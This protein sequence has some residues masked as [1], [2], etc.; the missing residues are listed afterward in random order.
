MLLTYSVH[1]LSAEV[2]PLVQLLR[3]KKP[4][5]ELEEQLDKI[6]E[7]ALEIDTETTTPQL[8]VIDALVTTLCYIGSKTFSHVLSFIERQR[9]RLLT[10]SSA[11]NNARYQV[12]TSVVDYW[13][14]V[15]PGVAVNIIDKLL[16]YGILTPSSVVEWALASERLNGGRVLAES[17]VYEMV[18]R[19]CGKVTGRVNQIVQARLQ[20]I[21]TAEQIEE[22]DATLATERQST[23]D[24]FAIID[25]ALVA[26]ADG[27]SDAVL[28]GGEGMLEVSEEDQDL[29]RLWGTKWRRV[30]ARKLAVLESTIVEGEKSFPGPY[31]EPA[32]VHA[33][34][35]A[36]MNGNGVRPEADGDMDT[37]G[38][39][40]IS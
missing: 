40:L 21:N 8:A 6:R 1:P 35:Y 26:V 20:T 22:L 11:P 19:T 10:L 25:D 14:E 37:A 31:E 2:K 39:D 36:E 7:K 32:P 34:G 24:L 18:S 29:L 23:R 33:D 30:F 15:Q 12:I 17:W 13:A 38:E 9:E 27:S 16:N 28:Q 5:A 4:D 3:K